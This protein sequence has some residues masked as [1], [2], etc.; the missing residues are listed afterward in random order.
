[1]LAAGHILFGQAGKVNGGKERLVLVEPEAE[2]RLNSKH[3]ST[4]FRWNGSEW[5]TE[6]PSERNARLAVETVEQGGGEWL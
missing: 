4:W 1:M 5:M 6:S 2:F 3:A